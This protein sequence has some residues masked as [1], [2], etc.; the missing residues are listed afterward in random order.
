MFLTSGNVRIEF[1]VLT[2]AVKSRILFAI[3][4]AEFSCLMHAFRRSWDEEVPV[5]NGKK[6]GEPGEHSIME[7]KTRKFQ[8]WGDE[9]C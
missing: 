6:T 1:G 7:V 5:R 4:V 8:R 3:K 9:H 2:V